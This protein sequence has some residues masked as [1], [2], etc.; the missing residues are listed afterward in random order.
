MV[1]IRGGLK[2]LG[3]SLVFVVMTS[4]AW[5]QT[6]TATSETAGAKANE[7]S[8]VVP[9]A[10]AG[11]A[12]G[13]KFA[14]SAGTSRGV[15]LKEQQKFEDPRTLTDPKLRAEEGSMSRYSI[16]V[17]LSYY[18]PTLGDLSAKDQPN[19]D[20]SVGMYATSLGGSVSARYRTAA[21]RAF[22][23]GTGLKAI[24][25][26]HGIER[27]DVN[28]P[29]L[30]YDISNRWG[31]LQMR[32]SPGVSYITVPNYKKIGEYAALSFGNSL[33]YDFTGTA[34]A[35]GLDTD[36]GYYLYDREYRPSDGKASRFTFSFGP[37]LKYRISEKLNV[38]TRMAVNFWNPRALANEW[39]LWNRSPTMSLGLAY[40]LT[41]EIY[42]SPYLYFYPNRIAA[43][44]VSMN[45]STI[46]SVL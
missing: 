43:D 41:K 6:E 29:Y 40:G 34:F 36:F 31:A 23:F 19:P 5:A 28:N 1:R 42:L 10:P 7:T 22:S 16:K 46:F 45:M 39:A 37:S 18:G 14:D 21:N 38:N 9:S 11:G 2:V 33:V 35:F 20:G 12:S 32:N 17:N 8:S 44:T 25:P 13:V 26:L 27:F 30:A 4:G 24:Y 3:K 15:L